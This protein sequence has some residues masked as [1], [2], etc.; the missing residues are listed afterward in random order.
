[1]N[2]ASLLEAISEAAPCGPD[3]EYDRDFLALD[4]CLDMAYAER[5][6]GP[7]NELVTPDW[8]Q[9]ASR[10]L[11]LSERTRDL[12]VVVLLT[13][14]WLHLHGV[15]G[16][17]RGL[18]LLRNLL[19][20]RWDSVHPQIGAQ[21]D[22]E[23]LMRMNALR[24][25]CDLRSVIGAIRS[26]VLVRAKGLGQLNLRELENAAAGGQPADGTVDVSQVDA[27]FVG[28]ELEELSATCDAIAASRA[29]LTG[30]EQLFQEHGARSPLRLS[31]L[32]TQ[33]DNMQSLLA[34]RLRARLEGQLAMESAKAASDAAI[35]GAANGNGVNGA[36]V[37]NA[38]TFS[39]TAPTTRAQVI[40]QLELICS[41]YAQHEPSSPI[42]LLLR[43]VKRLAGMQFI[44]IVRDLAPAGLAEIENL[45]GPNHTENP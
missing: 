21:G 35:S 24:S 37:T 9:I 15:T 1:M 4:A 6:L 22:T 3:L 14:A 45:A 42:P 23:G 8:Q 18:S 28:C 43:R 27:C 39:K 25:L 10:A 19:A 33:L 16:L 13:K 41:Y 20:R 44:D 17:A 5:A 2:Q 26:A 32:A 29:D 12:R 34:P 7:D 38:S 30:L 36:A 40:D 31:E 11:S